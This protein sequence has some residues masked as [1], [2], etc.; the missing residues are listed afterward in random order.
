LG[1]NNLELDA[2]PIHWN[3]DGKYV[4]I[5]IS[6]PVEGPGDKYYDGEGLFR[7]DL[8]NGQIS[9]ILP[10]C[11]SQNCQKNFNSFSISP[12]D[13]KLV[14]IDKTNHGLAL[15]IVDIITG[16]G[17]TIFLDRIYTDAGQ[18]YWS[19]DGLRLITA[20]AGPQNEQK[21]QVSPFPLAPS[22][23]DIMITNV[24]TLPSQSFRID[25]VD[26]LSFTD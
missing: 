22:F 16:K 15:V 1:F 25:K 9:T 14:F 6:G 19:E 17:H 23:T 18:F 13:Q 2:I 24:S 12:T 3:R 8:D 5:T 21:N 20:L 4:Y 10:A 11:F 7:V 26:Y